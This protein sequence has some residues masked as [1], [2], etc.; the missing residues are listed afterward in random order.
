MGYYG[1][2]IK[3]NYGDKRDERDNNETEY[4][5]FLAV[6][7]VSAVFLITLFTFHLSVFSLYASQT[8]HFSP[9]TFQFSVFLLPLHFRNKI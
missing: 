9:F 1:L 6:S 7:T 8:P 4:H 3:I 5:Q 2:L